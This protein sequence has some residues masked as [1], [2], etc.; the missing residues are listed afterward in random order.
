MPHRIL[1]VLVGSVGGL[2]LAGCSSAPPAMDFPAYGSM[3]VAQRFDG[4]GSYT[5]AVTADS[6][7]AQ[8]YFDQGLNWLYAFNHDE[9]VVSFAHAAELDPGCAMAWWGVAY[10]QGPNYNDPMMPPS[11]WAA[12]WEATQKALAALDDETPL[13]QSMVRALVNRY[14]AEPMEDRRELDQAFAEVMGRLAASN[15]DDP[16]LAT[17]HAES[18]M[19]QFPWKLHT[20]DGEPARDATLEIIA[21]LERAIAARPDH[22]GANHLYI[23]AIEPSN[24]KERAIPAADRLCDAMPTAGHILHMPSHIYVQVGMWDRSIVQNRRAM[25]ADARYRE[26]SPGQLIQHGY[27]AHNAHMLAFSAMMVGR[28]EEAMAAARSIWEQFP[29]EVLEAF[30]PFVDPLMCSVYDV[31][32]RFGRW[33]ELIAEPPPP[34]FLPMTTAVWHAHRAVAFAAKKDFESAMAEQAAFRSMIGTIPPSPMYGDIVS[35]MLVSEYF[36]AGEIALHQGDYEEASARLEQA[37][38]IEDSLGYGEPPWWL[39]PARHTLGAIRLAAG[40]AAGAERVYRADLERWPRNGWSLI[41]LSQA[42]GAQG[43]VAGATAAREE[44]DAVWA[45][46]DQMI[47]SSCQC[48]PEL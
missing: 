25:A 10:A 48:I 5:R 15:P 29:G 13:E 37:V 1:V 20:I 4:L 22:P 8:A 35:F 38:R 17:L 36:V 24:D 2:L 31:Q 3:G 27:M 12:S 14:A 47:A 26:R 42:L 9:A 39:Q 11:R 7:E 19:V 44:F 40:D 21:T 46:A 32:K 23:H 41:G 30:A 43:D 34:A 28:E 16:D 33:D 18:L 6:A 45:A